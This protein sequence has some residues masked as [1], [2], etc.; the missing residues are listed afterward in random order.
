[1]SKNFKISEGVKKSWEDPAVREKRRQRH[2]VSVSR[3]GVHVGDFT[4]LYQAFKALGLPE[5]KH[6]PFRI[7]LKESGSKTFNDGKSVYLFTIIPPLKKS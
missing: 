3:D 5:E 7:K 4:S 2:G 6:I 1:M